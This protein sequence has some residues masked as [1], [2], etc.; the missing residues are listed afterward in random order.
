MSCTPRFWLEASLQFQLIQHTQPELRALVLAYRDAQDFFP[1]FLVDPQYYVGRRLADH[2]VLPHV[3]HDGVDVHDG[4]YCA[5]WPLLPRL[6]LWQQL[7]RD[8][9]DHPFTDLE[10]VDVLDLL[11]DLRHAHPPSVHRKT[12]A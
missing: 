1:A 2:V 4:I 10:P 3:E 12:A 8:R 5:Q 11:R 9:C 6:D 7:V